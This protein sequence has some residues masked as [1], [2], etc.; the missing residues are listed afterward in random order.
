MHTQKKGFA[1]MG[2]SLLDDTPGTK[3]SPRSPTA[4]PRAARPYIHTGIKMS[5]RGYEGIK[6]GEAGIQ[7]ENTEQAC[8]KNQTISLKK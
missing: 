7:V 5:S 2:L 3:R 8:Y 4:L 6:K 1:K